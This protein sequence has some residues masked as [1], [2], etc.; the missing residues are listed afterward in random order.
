MWLTASTGSDAY[1]M[2]SQHLIVT[3]SSHNI[4]WYKVTN[5]ETIQVLP[6][7]SLTASHVSSVSMKGDVVVVTLQ[8][9]S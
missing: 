4:T 2:E 7:N 5:K 3:D 9:L 6:I 1:V 8:H